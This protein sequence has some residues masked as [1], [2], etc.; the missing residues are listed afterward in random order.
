MQHLEQ[1]GVEVYEAS[2]E[3]GRTLRAQEIKTA[4]VSSSKNCAAALEAAATSCRPHAGRASRPRTPLC[5]SDPSP[6]SG[7]WPP[8][9]SPT[10]AMVYWVWMR[11]R[12]VWSWSRDRPSSRASRAV[13]PP[14]QGR[15][16]AAPGLVE[17]DGS[18]QRRYRLIGCRRHCTPDP[19]RAESVL[20]TEQPPIWAPAVRAFHACWVEMAFP[21]EGAA[22]IVQQIG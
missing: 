11:C 19:G 15:A 20:C 4:V 13:G 22:V 1:H 16:A 2:I 7:T 10:S 14:W 9:I 5:A 21:P 8:P 18:W 17:A 3:L 6:G 12:R